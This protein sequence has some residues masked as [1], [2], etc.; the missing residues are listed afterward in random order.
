MK[1]LLCVAIIA[2]LCA[3]FVGC[4]KQGSSSSVQQSDLPAMAGN[5]QDDHHAYWGGQ[6]TCPVCGQ[7]P[8]KPKF[9]ADADQG[10]IYFDKKECVQKFKENSEKYI[11]KLKDQLK[12]SMGQ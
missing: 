11:K 7:E 10:R 6:K 2:M 9:H 4:Q 5:F 8:I 12:K 1:K 3:G